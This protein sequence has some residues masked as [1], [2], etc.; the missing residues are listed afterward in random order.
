MFLLWYLYRFNYLVISEI[1]YNYYALAVSLMLLFGGFVL[2]TI[3]WTYSLR[4]HG[5]IAG[6]R[7]GLISHGLSVFAKYIPGKVWVILGRASYMS[8][9]GL[10]FKMASMVSLKEQLIYLLWGLILSCIPVFVFLKQPVYGLIVLLSVF[11]IGFILFSG[12][13]HRQFVSTLTK[14]LKKKAELP[15]LT[16][17][18]A[19]KISRFVVLYWLV[20][21]F[22]FY[23]LLIAVFP[24][25]S[26]F[27]AFAFPV[28]V[29]YGVLAVFMPG[30]IGVRESI[31]VAYLTAAGLSLEIA[32]TISVISRFWFIVGEVFLFLLALVLKTI[33]KGAD[34]PGYPS[35]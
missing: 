1:D 17:N 5:H 24:E 21:V 14:V 19:L 7:H 12:W 11:I 18:D 27:Y 6:L 35:T 34:Y 8:G 29:T 31:L 9:K 32:I 28:S 10:S 25:A 33:Y 26:F 13:F 22:A 30:G 15:L 20:W 16:F 4:V 2:S 23:F 3:S